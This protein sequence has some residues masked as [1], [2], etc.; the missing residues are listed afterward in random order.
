MT[1]LRDPNILT[2]FVVLGEVVLVLEDGSERHLRNP[3]DT[4]IQKGTMHA[5]RNPSQKWARWISILI[6]AEPAEAGGGPLRPEFKFLT[7]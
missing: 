7:E 5:W 2:L 1:F 3:G 4:V 6:A